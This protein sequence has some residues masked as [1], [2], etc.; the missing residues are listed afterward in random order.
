MLQF[1]VEDVNFCFEMLVDGDVWWGLVYVCSIFF[2]II[3]DNWNIEI[4]GNE[5]KFYGLDCLI[6]L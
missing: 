3:F 4:S 5:V 6:F 1:F 2:E